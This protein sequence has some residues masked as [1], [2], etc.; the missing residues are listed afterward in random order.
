MKKI[1]KQ[2][3]KEVKIFYF[4]INFK[5][6]GNESRKIFYCLMKFLIRLQFL[7]SFFIS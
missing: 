2:K 4:Y 6:V 7:N 3:Q 5:I 1:I